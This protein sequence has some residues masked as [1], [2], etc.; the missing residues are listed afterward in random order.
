M[1]LDRTLVAGLAGLI[2]IAAALGVQS[3]AAPQTTSSFV[4][5][6]IS[7]S[8]NCPNARSHK[9]VGTWSDQPVG[10]LALVLL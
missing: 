8:E 2:V 6:S 7:Q 5:V 9:A 4:G 10:S 1:T 3:R